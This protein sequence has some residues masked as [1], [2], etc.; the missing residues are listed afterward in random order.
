MG[1]KKKKNGPTIA[2]RADIHSLYERAVQSPDADVDFFSETFES[3][4]GR[5]ALSMREDFC[6]TAKLST[7]WCLSDDQR[8]AIGVDF[9]G[10][11]LE[12][13]R[14]R[15]IEPNADALAG[16]LT[17]IEGDVLE[18][19]TDPVDLV[20]A[21]NFSYLIFKERERLKRYLL[22]AL[23]ALEVGGLL[24]LELYGGSN[25]MEEHSEDRELHG[26]SYVWEQETFDPISNETLCHIHFRFPDGSKIESAFTYDWRL[27]GL[28]ELRDLLKEVGFGKVRV[29]WEEVEDD[30]DED[31][32]L[33]G[34]GDYVEV[35]TAEQQECWLAYLVAQR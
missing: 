26:V 21:M 34:T 5:K 15:N 22:N 31:G 20:C 27:W 18:V 12:S 29:Y 28:P 35:E 7:V 19:A 32:M 17:L 3:V 6:G 2:D 4:N 11:T 13:G 16:R 30:A 8:R 25:G 14:L 1:K 9:H 23:E 24:F 33:S 10:P